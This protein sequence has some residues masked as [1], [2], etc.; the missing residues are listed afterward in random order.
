MTGLPDNLQAAKDFA[1]GKLT[2]FAHVQGLLEGDVVVYE[3]VSPDRLKLYFFRR[4]TA[5]LG[6]LGVLFSLR[7]FPRL[8]EPRPMS[9]GPS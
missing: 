9:V 3:V 6:K 2:R 7:G 8:G 4:V 1:T 5:S